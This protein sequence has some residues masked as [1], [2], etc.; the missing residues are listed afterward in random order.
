MDIYHQI[1]KKYWGYDSFRPLQEDI[2]HAVSEGK[3]TLGLMPTGGGKSITFQVPTMCMEGICIVITPLISLMKDQV[4]NLTRLGIKATTIYSGMTR[5]EIIKRLDNCIFGDYKFLYISPERIN[6]EL[7]KAKLKAL[8][9]CLIVVDESHCI[10]QWG[11][12]FRPSYLNIASIREGLE[13]IPLL[14]L[15][16]T[17]TPE[18]TDDIQEKLHFREKNV[19]KKSFFRENLSYVVRTTDD[20]TGS[21]IDIL[22]KVA[23]SAIV[24]VRNRALTKEIATSL[25]Q[26]GISAN[27]YHAGINR[28]EK[29]NRQNKWKSG[30]NRVMVATN[31]F[32]MGIDKPD[33]RLVIHMEVPASPEEYYQEAG[34]AGRDEKKAYAVV[35]HSRKDNAVRKRRVSEQF[36]PREFILRV[37]DALCNYFEIAMG[38]GFFTTHNFSIQQFCAAFRFPLQQAHHALKILE[39]AGYIEYVEEPENRSRLLFFVTREDMYSIFH[40]E[41][42][43]EKVV[44]TILRSY[45]G[46]F[47]DYVFIDEALIAARTGLTRQQVYDILIRLAKS[48]IIGYVPQPKTPLI[49][50]TRSREELKHIVI[51][52]NIY[53]E[54]KE[55][56]KERVQSVLEYVNNEIYC[57]SQMLLRYF[58]EKEAAPCGVCDIC[59]QQK[60]RSLSDQRFEEIKQA[61]TAFLFDKEEPIYVKEAMAALP[62]PQKDCLQVIRFI[63]DNDSHFELAEGKIKLLKD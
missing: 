4:D 62:F 61:L 1:L 5:P 31:A 24:Y 2:I 58:G 47:A 10:S 53:E 26:A 55:R 57:R 38:Y 27:Y 56:Y 7:F 50:L 37:Y 21:L 35:L 12:D 49:T 41:D 28:E 48:R 54:R 8:N 15:T 52:K 44:K 16:A 3:D 30:E 13:D 25:Q 36:P 22:S 32:G 40:R 46:I 33:V 59:L 23:G 51:P 14:A 11:Y 63:A 18:V 43:T 29:E 6:T 19:F 20:K 9:V 45:T 42:K 34:R 17:A 39:L 60:N